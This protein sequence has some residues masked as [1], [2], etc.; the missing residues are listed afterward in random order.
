VKWRWLLGIGGIVVLAGLIVWV[1]VGSSGSDGSP[2]FSAS[3]SQARAECLFGTYVPSEPAGWRLEG[4]PVPR[5]LDAIENAPGAI[6]PDR[7]AVQVTL[8]PK[9][10]GEEVTLEGIRFDVKQLPLRPL[11]VVFYRPCKRHLVGPAIE[12]D[13][14]REGRVR[15]AKTVL[16]GTLGTGLQ[17][18][19]SAEP[20][21]FPWTV[22]LN[23]PLHLYLVVHGEHSYCSWKA[24]IP[25]SSGSSEG[26]IHVDNGG[27]GYFMTDSVGVGWAR[28]VN[29]QWVSGLAPTWTGVR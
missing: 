2:P 25:W 29:G 11:G 17:L 23:K 7:S 27:K 22:T 16:K 15:P 10:P 9:Q 18:P 4:E 5:K 13:L 26:V 19:D 1:A 24:L 12:A 21:R 8:R 20:I 6:Q 3:D 28:P 14:D